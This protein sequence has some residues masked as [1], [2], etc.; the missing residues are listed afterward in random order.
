MKVMIMAGGTGGHVFPALAVA[1]YMRSGGASIVWMGTRSGIE[2]RL[3]PEQDYPVEWVSVRGLRRKGWL[4]WL[5]APL[6][7][8]RAFLQAL[9]VLRRH[10]PAV[11]LGMGGFASGPGGLAAWLLRRPLVIHEQNASPGLTNRVLA[12]LASL[13]LEA[14]PGSF[15]PARRAHVV[16]NPV[17]RDIFQRCR[18]TRDN[19]S[20]PLRLLV[21]GGSQGALSLNRLVPEAVQGMAED[22]RPAV[23]HQAGRTLDAARE[24]HGENPGNLRLEAFIDDMAE[25]YAWADLAICRAGALTVAEL[26]AAGLPAILVPYPAAVDDHQSANGRYLENAGAALMIQQSALTAE[27]LREKLLEL[28][29][30]PDRLLEMSR[31]ARECAWPD[32]TE[33]IATCCASVARGGSA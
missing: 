4:A 24:V 13:T 19:P 3:V 1:D 20:V 11:V 17:R 23:W 12:R 15:P 18:K 8:L 26:A 14:L 16:G 2:A 32:A 21:L 5:W 29:T 28:T 10:K 33:T 30:D 25:A 6:A 9:R 7:L 31:A 27:G 22:V